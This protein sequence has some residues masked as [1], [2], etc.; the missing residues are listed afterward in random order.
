M[1]QGTRS[2]WMAALLALALGSGELV[3]Y[4][5][6]APH[7]EGLLS[8]AHHRAA[9]KAGRIVARDLSAFVVSRAQ[10][11]AGQL[12]VLGV[13]QTSRLY[14]LAL[15]ALGAADPAMGA[16]DVPE[17]CGGADP[18]CDIVVAGEPDVPCAESRGC[19]AVAGAGL[20]VPPCP[21]C[22]LCPAEA[23]APVAPVAPG[24]SGA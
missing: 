16:N 18:E 19:N 7:A 10:A 14:R 11:A 24:R 9:M 21:A 15:L 1:I 23:A 12:A 5:G 8:G 6:I 3:A 2:T 13:K 17:G 22:P 4:Q 20:A